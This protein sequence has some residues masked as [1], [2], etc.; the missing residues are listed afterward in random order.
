MC[1]RTGEQWLLTDNLDDARRR[2]Q[3]RLHE[4]QNVGLDLIGLATQELTGTLLL[5]AFESG[6]VGA[7]D[8][9]V[10]CLDE[11]LVK[12]LALLLFLRP[13]MGVCLGVDAVNLFVVLNQS[14]DSVGGELV[15]NLIAQDHVN[16]D[17]VGF[18]MDELVAE[19]L[20]MRLCGHICLGALGQHDG[21]ES[22][23]GIWRRKGLREASLVLR[24][25][26]ERAL[27]TVDT[28]KSLCQPRLNLGPEDNIDGGCARRKG[29][30]R[31]RK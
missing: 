31:R 20:L 4:G 30:S 7:E 13:V 27:D 1:W 3:E 22:P 19:V 23:D 28:L 11:V 6:D 26:V 8:E 24:D 9:L 18:E 16:V 5:E 15:G 12:L 17:D 29:S 21:S 2:R 14:V 10:D 25:A